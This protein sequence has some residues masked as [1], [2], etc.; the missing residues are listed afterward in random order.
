MAWD[1]RSNMSDEI[2]RALSTKNLTVEQV[3]ELYPDYPKDHD[4]IVGDKSQRP[5][6]DVRAG[7]VRR[8]P[9]PGDIDRADL[10]DAGSGPC[11]RRLPQGSTERRR[12]TAR[13]AGHRRRHRL[14]LVGRRR[15]PLDDRQA[16]PRQRPAPRAV[17]ARHLVPGR[18]A[19]PHR[20]RGVPV[21][22][23]GLLVLRH[24]GCRRRPQRPRRLG[25][26]DDVRRR[27]RPL[28]REGHRRHVRVRRQAAAGRDPPG[29][30]QGRRRQDRAHHGALDPAR[31]D[32]VRPRRRHRRRRHQQDQG[33]RRR[34]S[35]RWRCAGLR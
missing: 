23:G 29:D 20:Q 5:C 1:L 16:D 15:R 35:T 21:R 22:R 24:A 17:D 30:V 34:A 19:L 2:T 7:R 18:P 8:H 27:R 3:E 31:T 13:A 26:D 28:P 32:P 4:P 6:R 12:G 10:P 14:Q 11:G 25:R 9:R 33:S